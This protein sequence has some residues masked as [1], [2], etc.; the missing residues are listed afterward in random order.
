MLRQIRAKERPTLVS[1]ALAVEGKSIMNDEKQTRT[2]RAKARRRYIVNLMKENDAVRSI[3]LSRKFKCSTTSIRND[4]RHLRELG[5]ELHIK[6]GIISAEE[7]HRASIIREIKFPAN[8]KDAGVSILSYF[9]HVLEEKYPD[10]DATVV[11]SQKGENVILKVESDEGELE[12]IE[13]TLVDYGKVIKGKIAAKE[14]FPD[15]LASIELTN[16]L[17]LVKMELRLKEQT[18]NSLNTNQNQRIVSLENQVSD[19]R[20]LIGTQLNT[21]QDL[22]QTLSNIYR[23]N[24]VSSSVARAIDTI[25]KLAESGHS[26]KNEEELQKAL[27]SVKSENLSLFKQISASLLS[28]TNSVS[29]NIAT[30]WVQSVLSSLPK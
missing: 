9:S 13:E 27:L 26:T 8:F 21:V 1:N 3:D 16:K 10:T 14:L 18:F 20:N 23:D 22:S 28:F 24:H 2:Q 17:E 11:I 7:S 25:S 6:K 4:L 29:V 12:R 30:S 5:I 15:T 19:L